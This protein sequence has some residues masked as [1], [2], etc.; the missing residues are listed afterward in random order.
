MR[1][2]TEAR[3]YIMD[4]RNFKVFYGYRPEDPYHFE[5][6]VH[7]RFPNVKLSTFN[8]LIRKGLDEIAKVYEYRPNTIQFFMVYSHSLPIKIPIEIDTRGGGINAIYMTVLDKNEQWI[9]KNKET[10]IMLRESQELEILTEAP[11]MTYRDD[12]GTKQGVDL[13]F[14]LYTHQ[15]ILDRILKLIS[16][17]EVIDHRGNVVKL[18][19]KEEIF[20]LCQSFLS[21]MIFRGWLHAQFSDIEQDVLDVLNKVVDEYKSQYSTVQV[22]V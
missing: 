16:G 1:I 5:G 12:S 11:W 22:A 20:D 10:K 4:Y 6:R 19:T 7:Q 15:E 8:K 21:G 9:D 14:E 17:Q 13:E 3:K 18:A 2:I